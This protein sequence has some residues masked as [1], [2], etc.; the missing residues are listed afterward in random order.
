MHSPRRADT[1]TEPLQLAWAARSPLRA[2]VPPLTDLA[3][4]TLAANPESIHDLQW[5]AEHLA[6]ALLYRLMKLGKL[7]FRLA[8]V[9]R[10]SGHQPIREAI[11][12][13]DLLGSMPTHNSIGSR[14][15]CRY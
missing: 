1:T 2:S 5:T 13:L 12:S 15:G 10:D 4:D 7:D 14:S 8:C 3:L 6:I 9:F 11:E